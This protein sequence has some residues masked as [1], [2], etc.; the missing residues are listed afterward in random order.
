MKHIPFDLLEELTETMSDDEIAKTLG[1]ARVTVTDKRKRLGIKSFFEKTG[2]KK[3][4]NAVYLGGRPRQIT[5]NEGFFEDISSKERAYFLGLLLAD[6]SVSRDLNHVEITLSDPDWVLL[7]QLRVSLEAHEAELKNKKVSK[8]KKPAK[9]LTLCSQRLAKSLVAWGMV[10]A[11]TYSWD[12]KKEIPKEFLAPF[13][14]GYWDG[15]GSIGEKFFSIAVCAPEFAKTLKKHLT[16]LNEGIPPLERVF[17]TKN[18]TLMYEFSINSTQHKTIRDKL[19]EDPSP[20]FL[21]K[22]EEY[23]KHWC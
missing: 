10:P 11:R 20:C 3:R 1:V 14:R 13:V 12:L 7:E 9:R 21:R 4:E 19:Y 8:N 23:L 17:V 22:Y 16:V 18:F 6:G 5:F 15:D 2:L